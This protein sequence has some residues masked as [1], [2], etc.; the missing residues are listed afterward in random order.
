MF[1]TVLYIDAATSGSLPVPSLPS[2]KDI[3]SFW[4]GVEVIPA[5]GYEG[6]LE[7]KF[8]AHGSAYCLPR[9]HACFGI[10]KLP[11]CHTTI[12]NFFAHMDRGV[13]GSLGHFGI[14]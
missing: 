10:I 14:I 12:D 6:Q 7:V 4:T 8:M 11:T 1:C 5:I 3:L 2:L 13:V 9:S